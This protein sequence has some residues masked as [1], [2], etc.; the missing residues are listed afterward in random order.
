MDF[1]REELINKIKSVRQ[2]VFERLE[3]LESKYTPEEWEKDGNKI[4]DEVFV[5]QYCL[6]YDAF[7]RYP[8]FE[9][10]CGVLIFSQYDDHLIKNHL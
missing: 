10:K 9:L 8:I 2:T 5:D 7:R 1:I 6:V 4:K 3:L